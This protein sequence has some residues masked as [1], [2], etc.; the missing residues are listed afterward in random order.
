[1]HIPPLFYD[2][3]CKEQTLLAFRFKT[4]RLLHERE[5]VTQG[6]LATRT[7]IS[8]RQLRRYESMTRLPVV[9]MNLLRCSLALG[10]SMEDLIAPDIVEALRRDVTARGVPQEPTRP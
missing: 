4:L 9:V 2:L 10:V 7:G 5:C 8:V 1:M 3:T 6:A